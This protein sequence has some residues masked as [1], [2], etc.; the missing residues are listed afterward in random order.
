MQLFGKTVP[1]AWLDI[2]SL[3]QSI[4]P[5]AVLAG[6]CLRDL[7]LGGEV[8]DLDIF[9]DASSEIGWEDIQH[10]LTLRHGWR[11]SMTVNTDY[12]QTM[13]SE[14]AK[15]VGFRVPS[16]PLEVQIVGLRS[17]KSPEDAIDRMDFGACQIGIHGPAHFVFTPSFMNDFLDRT[18]TMLEPEDHVQECRSLARSARFADKYAGTDVLVIPN[19]PTTR[20]SHS[21][22][23]TDMDAYDETLR[24]FVAGC[25]DGV[26]GG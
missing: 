7:I 10:V 14:V 8:K 15:V 2:L 6:G 5:S 9:V 17:L 21:F 20:I 12:V 19:G 3:I 23:D 4:A 22:H 26:M 1:P 16:F 13:R 25:Y 24:A 11:V 18:I